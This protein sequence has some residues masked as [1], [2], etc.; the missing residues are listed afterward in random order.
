MIKNLI[1]DCS[2]TLLR[3]GGL[4][5]L[6]E[7]TGDEDRS[8]LIHRAMFLLP[9][10]ALYDKGELDS[11][12]T[13]K[14]LIAALGEE[15]RELGAEYFDTW[16]RKHTIIEGIPELLSEL[17]EKGYKLY[18]LSDYPICFEHV[19]ES[20]E[21]FDMFDGRGVSYELGWRKRE[22]KAFP[23]LLERYSLRAEECFFV[24]DLGLNIDAAIECGLG[25][26]KFTSTEDLREE[27]NKL[28]IL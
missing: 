5:W 15:D 9:E 16:Y 23:L 28:G 2:D 20:F 13:K 7:V 10:W 14:K 3:F 12:T 22:K 6:R 19:W 24:D 27:L 1:F 8:M 4:R 18:L 26:H 11:E 21:L 17:K 25:A